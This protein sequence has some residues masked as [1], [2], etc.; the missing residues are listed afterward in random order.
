MQVTACCLQ[1]E[2]SP[3]RSR[4]AENGIETVGLDLTSVDSMNSIRKIVQ[5]KF[6]SKG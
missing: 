5:Q 1:P 4:L 2:T 3:G 6:E